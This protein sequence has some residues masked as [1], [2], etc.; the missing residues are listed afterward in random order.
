MLQSLN[1]FQGVS[2]IV[3][4]SRLKLV[5]D[6]CWKNFFFRY[7]VYLDR[8]QLEKTS[9]WKLQVNNLHLII[10]LVVGFPT[11]SLSLL[12]FLK[13]WSPLVRRHLFDHLLW[14]IFRSS[15]THV[16]QYTVAFLVFIIQSVCWNTL[17]YILHTVSFA[18]YFFSI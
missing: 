15:F 13:V 9:S 1:N 7:T 12:F 2:A 3:V 17:C 18:L 6:F 14:S 10:C 4:I 5:F 11:L 8:V 16:T